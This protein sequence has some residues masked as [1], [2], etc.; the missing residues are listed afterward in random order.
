MKELMARTKLIAVLAITVVV[1]VIGVL[2]LRDRLSPAPI[3]S[4]GIEWVDTE[5]G[6]QVK[7]VKRDSPLAFTVKKGDYIRAVYFVGKRPPVDGS[8]SLEYA[9]VKKVEDIH[10]YLD[11]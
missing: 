7:A 11:G 8:K 6:V 3:P 10:R 5:Q 2:N 1:V 9:E 4:D